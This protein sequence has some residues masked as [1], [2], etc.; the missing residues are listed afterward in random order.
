MQIANFRQ[1]RSGYSEHRTDQQLQRNLTN[2]VCQS[3]TKHKNCGYYIAPLLKYK[4]EIVYL[5][6]SPA[7]FL[8]PKIG[9]MKQQILILT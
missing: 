9:L 5:K 8:F 7:M 6:D 1:W 2:A 3:N 4:I